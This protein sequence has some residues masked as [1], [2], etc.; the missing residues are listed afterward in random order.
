[1]KK[2]NRKKIKVTWVSK[3]QIEVKETDFSNGKIK[4][5]ANYVFKRKK[6][7]QATQEAI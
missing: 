2:R 3:D 5:S 6:P 7:S 4:L 1:M